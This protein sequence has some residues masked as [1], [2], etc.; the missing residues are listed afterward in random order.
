[1]ITGY[2]IIFPLLI[3]A[4]A[5]V[6]SAQSSREDTSF[7]EEDS[8]IRERRLA[9]EAVA[10]YKTLYNPVLGFQQAHYDY[11]STITQMRRARA[12][13][14]R[15]QALLTVLDEMKT[16]YSTMK[17]L[18]GDSTLL[19]DLK[20][21]V[22]LTHVV[23]K[24]DFDKILDMEDISEQSYD[25]AEAY[26]LALDMAI[27]K[28]Q[29]SYKTLHEQETAFF[30]EYGI[31]VKK[32]KSELTLKIEKANRALE[33]FNDISRI[34]SRANRQ[35]N[36][37]GAAVQTKDVAGLEQHMMTLVSF[38][39]EGLE[40]LKQMKGYDGDSELL[41][42]AVKMLTFY[43]NAGQT[44][45]PANVEFFIKTDN[46]QKLAKRFKT[47]KDKDKTR[48]DINQYN[49]AVNSYNKAVKDINKINKTSYAQG[50]KL[51][52]LW[53]NGREKFFKNHS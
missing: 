28:L 8:V 34:V 35:N 25:K 44:T 46:F 43:Q 41:S 42:T 2:R 20:T 52:K 17:A 5:I 22:N 51:I 39:E 12:V 50:K 48:E 11:I 21:Y 32:E 9:V 1:M 13:E 10:Y 53:N 49:K 31:K 47:I 45:Y 40:K 38:A 18:H 3:S 24:E 36:Y 33:Y 29:N 19:T 7:V 6:V 23:L 26:E 37:T 14:K 27:E 16:Y 4:C 30:K 15:R